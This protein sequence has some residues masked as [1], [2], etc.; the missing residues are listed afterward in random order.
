LFHNVADQPHWL[1]L[2]RVADVRAKKT[3]KAQ[4]RLTDFRDMATDEK[5][6]NCIMIIQVPLLF[7]KPVYRGGGSYKLMSM[8]MMSMSK[9]SYE[10]D[11]D[12]EE[13]TRESSCESKETGL[14]MGN[15]QVGLA[16]DKKNCDT[17]DKYIYP[18]T[19][20]TFKMQRDSG[21][22]V[23]VTFQYYRAA[24]SAKIPS[25]EV[26]NIIEQ[27]LQPIK[28]ASAMGSLVTGTSTRPTESIVKLT[29]PVYNMA[30]F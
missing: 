19:A 28:V 10:D 24:D 23:R 13:D 21:Y 29:P 30:N 1:K 7:E 20:K 9:N 3:G 6:E 17:N 4:E 15:V 22:P 2:E 18:D 12:E 26:D 11:C 5:E 14:D 8:S 16:V 25:K 27:L